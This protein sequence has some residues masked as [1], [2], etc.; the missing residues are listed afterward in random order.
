MT[1]QK[2][3]VRT[4]RLISIR[5]LFISAYPFEEQ[6]NM[7]FQ[8]QGRAVAVM[9]LNTE[10]NYKKLQTSYELKP[11][12]GLQTATSLEKEQNKRKNVLLTDFG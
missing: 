8:I 10:I 1:G 2:V 4:Q 5:Y 11:F 3:E 12:H 9:C 7:R 6:K